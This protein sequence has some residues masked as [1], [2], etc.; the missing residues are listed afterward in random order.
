MMYLTMY[1]TLTDFLRRSGDVLRDVADR[2]VVLQRRDADDLVLT[3]HP[4]AQALK[5][6]IELLAGLVRHASA[7]EAGRAVI[8]RALAASAPWTIVLSDAEQVHLARDIAEAAITS[9]ELDAA[10]PLVEALERWRRVARSR[11]RERP[12][13]AHETRP[14]SIPDDV[15]DPAIEKAKGIV[16]LPLHVRWST[17]TAPTT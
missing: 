5:G 12:V 8:A 4:R 1:V 3:T 13:S 17:P 2:D 15:D 6:A 16:E 11:A 9:S 10:E 14:V 7:D